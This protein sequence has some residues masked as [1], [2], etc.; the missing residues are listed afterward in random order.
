MKVFALSGGPFGDI[1]IFSNEI[2]AR[3]E[4]FIMCNHSDFE[5]T[6]LPCIVD[7]EES[8]KDYIFCPNLSLAKSCIPEQDW[9][10]IWE[11]VV[12]EIPDKAILSK[13]V[14]YQNEI[15]TWSIEKNKKDQVYEYSQ[16][17]SVN[18]DYSDVDGT[19][20]KFQFN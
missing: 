15:Y 2:K 3:Q 19:R 17:L 18:L 10:N 11:R 16:E 13:L 9:K 12:E 8:G 14:K 5:Y 6:L 4:M 1:K 7:S 20:P